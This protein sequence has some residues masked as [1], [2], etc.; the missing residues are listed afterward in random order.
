MKRVSPKR[1]RAICTEEA[2]AAAADVE[3]LSAT[4]LRSTLLLNLNEHVLWLL[5]FGPPTRHPLAGQIA[6]TTN[7]R[8]NRFLLVSILPRPGKKRFCREILHVMEIFD[9]VYLTQVKTVGSLVWN[10]SEQT[11][12]LFCSPSPEQNPK[13]APSKPN[14][15]IY[16]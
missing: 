14:H 10:V 15:P 3:G 16:R 9:R 6:I 1:I 11:P 12:D 2:L 4:Q 13:P 7:P 5:H 8:K